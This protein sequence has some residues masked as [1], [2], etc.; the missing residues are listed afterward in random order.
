MGK[1]FYI[2]IPHPVPATRQRLGREASAWENIELPGLLPDEPMR[3]RHARQAAMAALGRA[4]GCTVWSDD[5]WGYALYPN[6]CNRVWRTWKWEG[7]E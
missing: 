5:G 7:E 3:P 4:H 2:E 6:G 1:W